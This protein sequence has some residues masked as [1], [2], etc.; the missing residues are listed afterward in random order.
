MSTPMILHLQAPPV[1]R[2]ELLRY[3]RC[4]SP[5]P[6]LETVLQ[7]VMAELLPLLDY[8]LSYCRLPLQK[9]G[10]T[11]CFGGIET[12]SHDLGK[13][14]DGCREVLVFAATVGLAPDRLV[15]KYGALSPAK[16]LCVQAVGAER[17]EALCDTFVKEQAE[18]LACEG[19]CLRP[20]FSPGY[21]DLP[22][23]LQRA[24]FSLLDC[25]R[26]IGLSLNESLLMSPTKSVTAIA[27]IGTKE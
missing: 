18:Q 27:G 2:G 1:D 21:G 20:R 12:D 23:E 13:A 8:K 14:L 3:L 19:L 6:E 7:Q 17:I 22:L 11:L 26:R 4:D 5:S 25:P 16:A 10:D 24:L 15:L 9:A